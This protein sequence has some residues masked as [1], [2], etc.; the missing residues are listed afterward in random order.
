MKL[1]KMVGAVVVIGA[2]IGALENKDKIKKTL[3]EQGGIIHDF[4]LEKVAEYEATH[5]D[6]NK[7]AECEA[8]SKEVTPVK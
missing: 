8:T 3:I 5:L 7:V 4:Y 1:F 6:S 2:V